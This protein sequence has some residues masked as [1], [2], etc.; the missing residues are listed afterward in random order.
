MIM[1]GLSCRR[2]A[3]RLELVCRPL[4]PARPTR[5]AP[6]GVLTHTTGRARPARVRCNRQDPVTRA[7]INAGRDQCSR[8]GAHEQGRDAR[9]PS[10]LLNDVEHHVA[11]GPDLPRHF[12]RHIGGRVVQSET[13]QQAVRLFDFSSVGDYRCAQ[14]VRSLGLDWSQVAAE[15]EG[16]PVPLDIGE[17]YHEAQRGP[18]ARYHAAVGIC[19]R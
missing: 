19:F 18:P 4:D 1:F 2:P 15:D 16:E 8:R 14:C 10:D 13:G 12:R 17:M 3:P 5:G 9:V 6:G 11:D 7:G